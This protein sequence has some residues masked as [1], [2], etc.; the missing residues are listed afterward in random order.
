MDN[1]DK[2]VNQ[3][4]QVLKLKVLERLVRTEA[5][6]IESS[7]NMLQAHSKKKKD[8]YIYIYIEREREIVSFST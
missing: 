6:Q 2:Q 7:R 3:K 4:E 8:M 5:E 1:Y